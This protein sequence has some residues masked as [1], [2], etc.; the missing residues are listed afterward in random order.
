M[1]VVKLTVREVDIGNVDHSITVWSPKKA[2]IGELVF[3]KGSVEWWPKGNKVNAHTYTW[4]QLAKVLE[5][6]S[7]VK[8]IISPPEPRAKKASSA[9][10]APSAAKKKANKSVTRKRA[11]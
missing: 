2:K 4:T 11:A 10:K 8:R 5:T 1:A 3:S 9:P 6:A 7:D